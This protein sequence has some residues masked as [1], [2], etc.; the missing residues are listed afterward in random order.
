MGCL[1]Y[2]AITGTHPIL[3]FNIMEATYL[4]PPPTSLLS[5][6]DLIARHTIAMQKR[7]IEVNK[8]LGRRDQFV[9]EVG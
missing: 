7:S 8:V 9:R 1:P 6:I 4:Q 2:F 3:P 5:S